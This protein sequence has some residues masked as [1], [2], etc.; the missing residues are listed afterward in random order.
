MRYPDCIDLSEDLLVMWGLD[1]GTLKVEGQEDVYLGKC[2]LDEPSHTRETEPS[3]GQVIQIDSLKIWPSKFSPKPP[4]GSVIVAPPNDTYWT[5]LTVTYKSQ[6]QC[7]EAGVRDLSIVPST[8]NAAT[9]YQASYKHGKAGEAKP[10]WH[11]LFSGQYPATSQDTVQA[12]FQPSPETAQIK[13]GSEFTR[14]VYRVTF[15]KPVPYPAPLTVAGGG[16]R[17]VDQTGEHFRV[18]EYHDAQR[19]DRLPVAIAMKITE[20]KEYFQGGT[21]PTILPPPTFPTP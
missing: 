6:L 1:S 7:W 12:H 10:R 5:I 4:L 11:G 3:D 17:L 18:L 14:L 2:I 8:L 9:V 20:G 15:M 16:F 21:P 13:F 19:I